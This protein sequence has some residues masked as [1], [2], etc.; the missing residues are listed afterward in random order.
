MYIETIK[1]AKNPYASIYTWLQ[2]PKY[3][4]KIAKLQY[5]LVKYNFVYAQM[6][7]KR[8]I[9]LIRESTKWLKD[10]KVI[11]NSG[12][13]ILFNLNEALQYLFIYLLYISIW[14]GPGMRSDQMNV[15]NQTEKSGYEL[16]KL[17]QWRNSGCFD[18]RGLPRNTRCSAS[19]VGGTLSMLLDCEILE[20][21]SCR[22]CDKK[23][24][25]L[26]TYNCKNNKSTSFYFLYTPQFW[27]SNWMNWKK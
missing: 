6:P 20:K 24:L 15:F 7:S 13:Y 27:Q 17:M 18:L 21:A 2:N 23:F 11:Y 19:F 4:L 3:T 25:F 1:N 5:N 10:L 12:L 14:Q 16:I 9:T 8:A 22:I 26:D